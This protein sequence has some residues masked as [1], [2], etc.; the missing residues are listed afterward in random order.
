MTMQF[1]IASNFIC[2]F[3]LHLHSSKHNGHPVLSETSH[4]HTSICT[5]VTLLTECL[6]KR[7]VTTRHTT[8]DGKDH[9]DERVLRTR[10]TGQL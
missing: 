5:H 9:V 8:Q 2:H 1:R 3:S 6:A 4:S 10:P 7:R